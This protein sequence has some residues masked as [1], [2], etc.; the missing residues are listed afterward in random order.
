[1]F[2]NYFII[3]LR[4]LFKNSVYSFINITG[5]AIGIA[6]S[7]LILLWVFDELSYDR[8][9]PKADRLYQVWIN[10]HF[11]GKVNSWTSVPLPTSEGLKTESSYIARTVSTDWGG[12]HL[13]TVGDQRITKRGFF[14]GE[15]F[16]N[17]FEFPLVFGDPKQVLTEPYTIVI[18]QAT[19]KA[20]FGDADP[21]NQIIR[22]D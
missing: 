1:M 4:N 20:L 18:S 10:A 13:L 19:A 11:D 15:E 17:M 21:I 14:A 12:D 6:C 7:V 8:F 9:H 16:L 3:T 22:V 5:L 2:K